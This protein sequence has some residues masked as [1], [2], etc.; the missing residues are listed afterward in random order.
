MSFLFGT[1]EDRRHKREVEELDQNYYKRRKVYN[2]T[3]EQQ[4]EKNARAA[5]IRDADKIAN[6]K[7]FY[8]KV[9]GVGLA[10]GK[11]MVHGASK[12]NPGV[13][14]NFDEPKQQR[15]KR[16]KRPGDNFDNQNL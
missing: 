15:R 2:Q 1:P 14:F 7:P 3:L 11:D 16:R 9:M 12:T 8:Q 13:L 6:R 4:R 10:L 5:A